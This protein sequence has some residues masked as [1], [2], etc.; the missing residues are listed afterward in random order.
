[1]SAQVKVTFWLLGCELRRVF[2]VA[3]WLIATSVVG[4]EEAKAYVDASPPEPSNN[5]KIGGE[6][7]PIHAYYYRSPPP[8]PKLSY[9]KP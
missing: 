8:P 3:I 2:A 4:D 9:N 1:M 5:K 7:L 6:P